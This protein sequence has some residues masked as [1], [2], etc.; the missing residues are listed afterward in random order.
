MRVLFDCRYVRTGRHDGISRYSAELVRELAKLTPVELLISDEAQLANLPAGLPW[1]LIGSQT[2]PGE[3]WRAREVNRLHPD[4]VF[5]PMQTMGSRGRKYKLVLTV[6]DLIYYVHRTPPRTMP[7]YVKIAWRLYHLAWW[8]QRMLLNGGDA[9]VSVSQTTA[10]LIAEHH[11]TRRPVFIVPNAAPEPSA[12]A[13]AQASARTPPV[14]APLRLVHMGQFVPYK[15][16]DA[17]VRAMPLLGRGYELHLMSPVT[18]AERTRLADLAPGAALVFH[19]GASDADYEAALLGAHALVTTSWDEG[20]GIPVIEAMR[21]GTPVVA[22]DIAIFREVG[23]EAAAFVDPASPA[24]VA[25]GIRSLESPDAWIAASRAGLVQAAAFNW[26]ASA[27]ALFE[28]LQS[29]D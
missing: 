24:D 7:W 25:R 4:V 9:V 23:G 18:A 6:H 21:L 28:M 29:L 26:A 22:S 13:L 19:D 8:P 2:G 14:D 16:I 17:L 11:L 12:G 3:P 10:D 15:N 27:R 1:H 20:F 5:T